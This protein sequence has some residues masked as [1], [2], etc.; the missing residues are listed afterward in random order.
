MKKILTILLIG[1]ICAITVFSAFGCTPKEVT[2]E[3]TEESVKGLSIVCDLQ[4][5]WKKATN[6]DASYPQ[7]ALVAKASL[8]DSNPELVD[9]IAKLTVENAKALQNDATSLI[10]CL[11]EK[12]ATVPPAFGADGVARTNIIPTFGAKARTDIENYFNI[13]LAFKP[14]LIG[15]KLP[16]DAFYYDSSAIESYIT[17]GQAVTVSKPSDVKTESI[18]IVL[19]DGG[20]ALAM[21]YLMKNY[22]EEIA[23]TK[24]TYKIVAGADEIKASVTNGEAD[25]AIMPTNLASILYNGGTPI[26]LIGTNSYGLLYLLSDSVKKESFSLESLK[27]QILHVVGQGGTPEIVLKK[28]LESANIEYV[29]GGDEAVEGKVV[30][31]YHTDGSEIIGAFVNEKIHFAVLGEPAA[32]TAIA[33]V[34]AAR[35]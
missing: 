34:A 1:A 2:P 7:T 30:I 25:I 27:G 15:K 17:S 35:S 3:D 12:G 21:A 9:L 6:T 18:T 4:A 32:S 33:K 5:E 14:Q 11:R 16:D 10:N 13:L 22:P 19:P 20:P 23:G 31:K 24:V 26:K 29:D 8:I 28:I